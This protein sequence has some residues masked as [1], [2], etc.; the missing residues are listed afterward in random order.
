MAEVQQA[1][2][3]NVMVFGVPSGTLN[4]AS[5]VSL[6]LLLSDVSIAK[7]ASEI[8]TPN[9]AGEVVNVTTWNQTITVTCTCRAIADTRA[10]AVTKLLLMPDPGA[11]VLAVTAGSPETFTDTDFTATSTGKS[12]GGVSA[13]RR[14]TNG[15][16]V[17]YDLVLR[18]IGAIT[19]Y[20]PV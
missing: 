4:N 8:L 12:W 16:H 11:E 18:R 17:D 2:T 5:N 6:G 19:D 14:A 15:A 10:N 20:T 9:I 3:G 7:S 13:T 1:T